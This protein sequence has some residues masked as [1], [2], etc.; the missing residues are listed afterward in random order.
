MHLCG[1]MRVSKIFIKHERLV[2]LRATPHVHKIVMCA[3]TGTKI[4]FGMVV[5]GCVCV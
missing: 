1:F 3:L 4:D 5:V 2:G